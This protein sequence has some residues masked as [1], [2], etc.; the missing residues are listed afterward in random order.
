[1]RAE[2]RQVLRPDQQ[3][4]FDEL[5]KSRPRKADGAGSAAAWSNRPAMQLPP[6]TNTP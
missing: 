2:I 4:K 5:L 1:V 6:L 3:K